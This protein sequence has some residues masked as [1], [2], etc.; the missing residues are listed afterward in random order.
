MEQEPSARDQVCSPGRA[1]DVAAVSDPLTREGQDAPVAG[2]AVRDEAG[3]GLGGQV[4][5][6]VRWGA[7]DQA[8]QQVVRI[9]L[10]VVLTRLTA[11]SEF[12]LIA[13][14]FLVTTIASWVTD[15]GF[16]SALVQRRTVTDLHVRTALTA[17]F[18]TGMVLGGVTCAVALPLAG[19]FDADR[20][21]L[22]LVV[23][24]VNFP[25]KGLAG[26]PRDLLRRELLFKPSALAAGV[27]V[28]V[29]A[30]VALVLALL[31]AG[32]WALVAYSVVESVAALLAYAW[33]ARRQLG[34]RVRPGFSGQAFR[35]LAGFGAS[36]SASR[37]VYYA[38]GNV[39]NLIVGKV[40]G[41]TA[42]GL[43]G[44]AYRIM[45]YPIQKAADVIVQVAM[46]AFST[47]QGDQARLRQA[48]LRGQ[49]AICLVCF[50]ASIG[51]SVC[52]PL[53]VPVLV[54]DQWL[55]AVASVQILALSGPRLALNRLNG[56]V[57]Q[58]CGR[59][60]LELVLA[61]VSLALLVP[62]FL[63][64]AGHGI[65]GVA[66]A[67]TVIGWLLVPVTQ[68]PVARLIGSSPART[69]AGLWPIVLATLLMA[70][71]SELARQLVTGQVPDA[72]ALAAVVAVGALTYLAVLLVVDR[73]VLRVL[74]GAFGR[75]RPA[76]AVAPAG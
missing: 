45:L 25:L 43:Y 31:G 7:A 3:P 6:G 29:S 9:S 76:D 50:P 27:G 20:L 17:T 51:I 23:L 8:F 5:S 4:R 15:L 74:F 30:G 72:L 22:V 12:G 52:A 26:I 41:A 53:L 34:H 11:P 33:F 47:L 57:F 56:S 59:P 64:G 75:G 55:P 40:L 39:D 36:V 58:A 46:P 44:L 70:G 54:G 35:D 65:G 16:G 69:L 1:H 21:A 32:V 13:L 18:V 42:L 62:G 24:S 49:Q 60:Q 14:A 73:P 2:P 67:F 37:L 28:A 19:Y 68:V 10:N 63:V 61:L 48:F 71:T 38:Q 66:T